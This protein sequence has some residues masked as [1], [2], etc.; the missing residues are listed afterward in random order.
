MGVVKYIKINGYRKLRKDIF[1]RQLLK[2]YLRKQ[3]VN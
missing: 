2:T 3:N 1:V